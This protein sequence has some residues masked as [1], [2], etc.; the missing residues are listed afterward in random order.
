LMA[1]LKLLKSMKIYWTNLERLVST[2]QN[3]SA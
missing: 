1:S 2:T 3:R